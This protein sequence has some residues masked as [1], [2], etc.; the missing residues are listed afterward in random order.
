METSSEQ[1]KIECPYCY[2][3]GTWDCE[4]CNGAGGCS[5]H[6]QPVNMGACNVCEGS[7][8]VIEGKY[9]MDANGRM[10]RQSG[11]CFI[12]SGPSTGYWADK[13]ALGY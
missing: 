9:D 10:L 5:C 8:Y 7:G 4:C 1:I 2:G 6:G 13:K 11:A 12:G 3:A